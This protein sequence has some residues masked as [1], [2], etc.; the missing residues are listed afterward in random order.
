[1]LIP[2]PNVMNLVAVAVVASGLR[3]V[4]VL[5]GPGFAVGAAVVVPAPC[6][7]DGGPDVSGLIEGVGILKEAGGETWEIDP[8]IGMVSVA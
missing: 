1:M 7:G 3:L 6:V 8:L 4:N 2:A 5:F